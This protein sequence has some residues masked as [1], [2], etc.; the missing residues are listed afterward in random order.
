MCRGDD[1]IAAFQ[2]KPPQGDVDCVGSVRARNATLHAK[3]SGPRLLE[4]VYVGSA[5]VRRLGNHFGNRPV[6]LLLDREVLGVQVNKRDFHRPE[7]KTRNSE[8]R[9]ISYPPTPRLRHGWKAT[10][11]TGWIARINA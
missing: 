9:R 11:E 1:F 2:A 10:E 5:I 3:C 6:D 8:V 7:V 4:C